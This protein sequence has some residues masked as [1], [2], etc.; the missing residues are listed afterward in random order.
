MKVFDLT[1]DAG[2]RF[3]GWFASAEQY[4]SQREA[5]AVRCPLCESSEIRREP[6]APRL[7][8]GSEEGVQENVAAPQS[9]AGGDDSTVVAAVFE[10][11]RRMVAETE[12][13]GARFA[14]EARRIHYDE[15][16]ARAIRGIASGEEQRALHDEGIETIRLPIP[17][18]LTETLQ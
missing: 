7:N 2:H 18:A 3:E 1:C 14:E 10:R 16:P 12:D 17:R 5:L 11:L 15:T 6:S 13:V 8:L 4:A 9:P